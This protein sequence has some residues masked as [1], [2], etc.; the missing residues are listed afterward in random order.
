MIAESKGGCEHLS[1]LSFTSLPG[2]VLYNCISPPV[3]FDVLI[4]D[5][6]HLNHKMLLKYLKKDGHRCTEAEDE[7]Q[8][9]DR[10]KEKIDISNGGFGLPLHAILMD[11]IMPNMDGTTAVKEIRSMGYTSLIFGVTG[12]GKI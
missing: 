9:I 7:I 1:L 10:V 12:N 8:A 11:F 4:E 6:S 3:P 2:S 5:D